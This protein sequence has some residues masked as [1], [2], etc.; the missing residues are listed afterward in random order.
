MPITGKGGMVH[1]LLVRLF[2]EIKLISNL[3]M[4]L[5]LP[6]L[7]RMN[8]G[9]LGGDL[10][11]TWD[12]ILLYDEQLGVKIGSVA[13]PTACVKNILADHVPSV[14]ADII[15]QYCRRTEFRTILDLQHPSNKDVQ[16]LLESFGCTIG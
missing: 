8:A 5:Q 12:S 1:R 10:P 15:V 13:E 14:L 9:Y 4:K 16:V 7:R 11:K 6:R 2:P 3:K